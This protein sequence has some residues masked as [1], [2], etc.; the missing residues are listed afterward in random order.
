MTVGQRPIQNKWAQFFSELFT[1]HKAYHSYYRLTG[2]DGV[3]HQFEVLEN[4]EVAK[5]QQWF[6]IFAERVEAISWYRA[7]GVCDRSTGVSAH[8]SFRIF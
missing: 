2:D 1:F 8:Q 7:Y 4:L 6:L 5:N 3:T